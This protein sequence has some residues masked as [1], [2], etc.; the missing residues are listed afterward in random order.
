MPR[1]TLAEEAEFKLPK[2]EPLPAEL[3]SVEVKHLEGTSTRTGKDY[4][5]DKWIWEF[6][7]IDGPYAGLRAWAETEDRLTTHPDNKVRQYAEALLGA[8]FEIGQDL[9]TD[10]LLGMPCEIVLDHVVEEGKDRNYYKCP[11][12]QVWP[13]GTSLAQQDATPPF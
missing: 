1:A 5:F 2:D 6:K 9:D 3:S 7:I 11:V 8:E 12:A 10:D 4:S 13:I